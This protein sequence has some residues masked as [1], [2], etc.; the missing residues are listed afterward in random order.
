MK[1]GREGW[2]GATKINNVLLFRTKQIYIHNQM[3]L[4]MNSKVLNLSLLRDIIGVNIF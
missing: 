1:Q 2:Q 3:K 4:N